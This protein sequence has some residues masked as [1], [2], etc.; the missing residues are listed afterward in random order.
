MIKTRKNNAG[1]S[2]LEILLAITLL[3][4]LMLSVYSIVNNSTNTKERITA[5]DKDFLQVEAFFARFD[6]D[7]SQ[8]YSPLYFSTRAKK[9]AADGQQTF[10]NDDSSSIQGQR[11]E[12]KAENDL[13]IPQVD[14]DTKGKLIFLTSSHRRR[15]VSSKESDYTWI[16]YEL[17]SSPEENK[18]APLVI[19]RNYQPQDVYGKNFKW[20]ENKDQ[21]ILKS[22]RDLEFGFWDE[23]KKGYVTATR[24]LG[25]AN[26]NL[27]RMVRI[28]LTWVDRDGNEHKYE[29]FFRPLWPYF[30]ALSATEEA[31]QTTMP[32]APGATDATSSGGESAA[33]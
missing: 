6:T 14:G 4:L 8:I 24:E 12:G 29:R 27:I 11:F 2:L 26:K 31:S 33:Q 19:V 23:V 28:K 16:S 1:F 18:V 13:P 7:F 30:K 5:E 9:Q 3:A 32:S 17:K 10:N 20:D 22:V 15:V 25:A 21:L